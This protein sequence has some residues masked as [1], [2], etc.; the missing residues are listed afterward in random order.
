MNKVLLSL[1]LLCAVGVA[2]KIVQARSAP[3]DVVAPV[4]AAG[5]ATMIDGRF[6]IRAEPS[7][8]ARFGAGAGIWAR[9]TWTTFVPRGGAAVRVPYDS[10][11]MTRSPS[12]TW[13]G[14]ATFL[15]RMDGVTFLTD[16]MFSN[17]AGPVSIFGSR[18]AVPLRNSVR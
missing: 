10:V 4:S 15:V 9:K 17:W 8:R 16:P 2:V 3:E 12:V 1:I 11:A 6:K 13:I 5:G 7:E 14:H 18:R